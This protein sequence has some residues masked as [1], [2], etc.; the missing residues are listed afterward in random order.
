MSTP[1]GKFLGVDIGQ[2]CRNWTKDYSNSN[3]RMPNESAAIGMLA[4]GINV[5]TAKHPKYIF[6]KAWPISN[7][8]EVDVENIASF[9]WNDAY[10]VELISNNTLV[11]RALMLPPTNT[12]NIAQSNLQVTNSITVGGGFPPFSNVNADHLIEVTK[13]WPRG[14]AKDYAS[15]SLS[16]VGNARVVALS[17]EELKYDGLEEQWRE[18]EYIPH[19][20]L[21]APP[22]GGRVVQKEIGRAAAQLHELRTKKL[23]RA[24]CYTAQGTSASPTPPGNASGFAVNTDSYV[25][26]LDQSITTRTETSPGAVTDVQYGGVGPETQPPGQRVKVRCMVLANANSDSAIKFIGPTHIANNEVEVPI[27]TNGGLAWY[28]NADHYIYLNPTIAGKTIYNAEMNKIDFLGKAAANGDSLRIFA[29]YG[30]IE[31]ENNH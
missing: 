28:G 9:K 11:I 3:V 7:V 30:Q 1:V 20:F 14:T 5:L 31:Y 22:A 10:G 4:Q 6:Q 25:N 15:N 29:L 12:A 16:T 24:F 19:T 8:P 18:D 23:G 27:P 13:H 17:I 21:V 26:L 2:V